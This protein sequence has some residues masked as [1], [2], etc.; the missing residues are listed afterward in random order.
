MK[1]LFETLV[2]IVGSLGGTGVLILGLSA[3]L[4]KVWANRLMTN[5]KAQFETDLEAI[6]SNYTSQLEILKNRLIQDTERYKIKLKKSEF[7]FQKEYEAASEFVSFKCSLLHSIEYPD[8]EWQDALGYI[9]AQFKEIE[10]FLGS[11]LAKHGAILPEEVKDEI[12]SA[13]GIAGS[14]K[15]VRADTGFPVYPDENLREAQVLYE[16][17]NG[18]EKRLIE[19]VHSQS[20]T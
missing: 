10:I 11:F 3:W 13:S 17:L 1:D 4:G 7:I 8:M 18:I 9:A 19:Q 15:F 20:S 16:L 12:N 14:G 2:V 6:K 5:E